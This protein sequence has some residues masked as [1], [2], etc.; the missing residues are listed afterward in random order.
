MGLR[1]NRIIG[2]YVITRLISDEASTRLYKGFNMETGEKVAMKCPKYGCDQ[3]ARELEILPQLSHDRIIELRDFIPTEYGSCLVFPYAPGG[4]LFTVLAHGGI[5]EI[6]TRCVVYHILEVLDY[7]HGQNIWHR[8]VKPEN[9]LITSREF[10]PHSVILSDFGFCRRFEDEWCTAGCG[11]PH[12]CAPELHLQQPYN[13]KADIWALGVTMFACLA[14]RFPFD[15]SSPRRAYSDI[16]SGLPHLEDFICLDFVSTEGRDLLRKM[17]TKD[18][19]NRISA[20]DAL[21]HPWFDL[22]RTAND[23]WNKVDICASRA[24][25]AT[26]RF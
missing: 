16:V 10:D 9:I 22:F 18:I 13:E 26:C 4:D 14:A 15:I 6:N 11:S 24:A 12:Y 1:E 20:H 19:G 21:E 17:L 8:D 2:N 25:C 3:T 7:L 5:G 23:S